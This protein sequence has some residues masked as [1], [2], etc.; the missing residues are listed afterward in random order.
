[1]QTGVNDYYIKLFSMSCAIYSNL[2]VA[3]T[4]LVHQ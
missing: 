2:V 4:T 1:M 3:G